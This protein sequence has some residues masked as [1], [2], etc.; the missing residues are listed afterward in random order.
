MAPMGTIAVSQLEN[1]RPD[2][3]STDLSALLNLVDPSGLIHDGCDG[4]SMLRADRASRS[5]VD[6]DSNLLFTLV[7]DPLRAI[8]R[9]LSDDDRFCMR[10]ACRTTRDHAEPAASRLSRASFLRSRSLTIYA[11]DELS[12]FVLANKA[13]MLALPA[14]VGCVAALAELMDARGCGGTAAGPD[15]HARACCA[16][17]AHGQLEA[18]VWLRGRGCPWSTFVCMSAA[19]AGHLEVLRYAHEHGRPWDS[20]T[21]KDAARGGHLEVLRYAHEHGCPWDSST[22]YAA[23]KGGHL[24]VLRYAHEHGCPWI[25]YTCSGRRPSRGAAVLAR[26]R[27]PV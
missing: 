5:E 22:C 6:S 9:L 1:A 23:V 7:G 26:A 19:G 24:E 10:L 18:L 17:A 4:P 13:R 16:A 14:T 2:R 27:L 25:A 3:V 8:A 11:C 21:C 15:P 20:S 12:G